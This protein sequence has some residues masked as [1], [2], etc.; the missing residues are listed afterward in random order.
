[1]ILIYLFKYHSLCNNLG[2]TKI[3]SNPSS[4]SPYLLGQSRKHLTMGVHTVQIGSI[5]YLY[6]NQINLF[7]IKI[8]VSNSNQ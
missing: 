7:G 3:Q 4:T 2:K 1:M 8:F 5:Y 6:L